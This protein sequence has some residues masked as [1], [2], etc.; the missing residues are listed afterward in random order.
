MANRMPVYYLCRVKS[1]YWYDYA[2]VVEDLH[3]SPGYPWVDDRFTKM[4][5]LSGRQRYYLRA[6]LFRAKTKQWLRGRGVSASDGAV[7]RRLIDAAV[8]LQSAWHE[9]QRPVSLIADAFTLPHLMSAVEL[10]YLC[11]GS[12]LCALRDRCDEPMTSFFHEVHP[13]AAISQLLGLL[14]AAD[15]A[16][17]DRIPDEARRLY[18]HLAK[19]LKDFLTIEVPWSGNA[20]SMPLQ[21]LILANFTRLDSVVQEVG[22]NRALRQAA[23]TLEQ[24]ADWVQQRILK[25]VLTK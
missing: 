1:D 18:V 12:D 14:P 3:V 6:S 4:M 8:V 2:L 5:T 7:D 19:R 13:N 10:L 16:G 23:W 11:L 22:G 25:A 20:G 24:E 17:L 15:G 21:K 9:D